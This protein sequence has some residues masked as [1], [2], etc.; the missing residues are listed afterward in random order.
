VCSINDLNTKKKL[1][2]GDI[3]AKVRVGREDVF[4]PTIGNESL[5]RSSNNNGVIVLKF[6]MSKDVSKEG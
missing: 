1:L 2:L 4:K 6:V 3:S 5:H